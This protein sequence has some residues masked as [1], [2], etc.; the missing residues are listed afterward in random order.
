MS[1]TNQ[2]A[3]NRA[4]YTAGLRAL[5]DILDADPNLPLPDPGWETCLDIFVDGNATDAYLATIGGH[6]RYRKERPGFRRDYFPHLYQCE[7]RGVSIMIHSHLF[8]GDSAA[9]ARRSK[10]ATATEETLPTNPIPADAAWDTDYSTF[11]NPSVCAICIGALPFHQ[12]GLP[13]QAAHTRHAAP[14]A[15]QETR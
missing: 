10:G 7:L 3:R 13:I 11:P 12:A 9:L 15:P 8:A 5:A 4:K 6:V 2:R 1:G 14:A